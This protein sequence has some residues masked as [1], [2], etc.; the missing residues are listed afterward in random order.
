[1][2]GIIAAIVLLAMMFVFTVT[3]EEFERA[4]STNYKPSYPSLIY[5]DGSTAADRVYELIANDP[6]GFI[7]WLYDRWT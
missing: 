5:Y 2:N 3:G 1:M 7:N 4:D 6:R